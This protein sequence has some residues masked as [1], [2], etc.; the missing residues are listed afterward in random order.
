MRRPKP[1]RKPAAP[2]IVTRRTVRVRQTDSGSLVSTRVLTPA[3]TPLTASHS[4]P[5]RTL[6]ERVSR[7]DV[8]AEGCAQG[9]HL[10]PGFTRCR[11]VWPNNSQGR[12]NARRTAAVV[13][14]AD[15]LTD[16]AM[17]YAVRCQIRD[18]AMIAERCPQARF[19]LVEY[20]T[21][22]GH[23]V[24]EPFDAVLALLTND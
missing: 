6:P 3:G 24:A 16:H 23:T 14:R 4:V 15:V 1:Y 5:G 12:R 18:L 11:L 8:R 10:A 21:G 19:A 22:Q 20:A 9:R 2:R 17:P 13:Q 7:T